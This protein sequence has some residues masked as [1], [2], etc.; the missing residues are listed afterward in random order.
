[1]QAKWAAVGATFLLSVNPASGQD[2][3]HRP[4]TMV[5]SRL[6]AGQSMSLGA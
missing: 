5:V 4:V 6:R 3:P 1:M 2:W